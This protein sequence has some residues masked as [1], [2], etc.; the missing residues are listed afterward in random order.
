MCEV[1]YVCVRLCLNLKEIK[2][3][4]T[5]YQRNILGLL[6]ICSAIFDPVQWK[7]EVSPQRQPLCFNYL[8]EQKDCL[9]THCTKS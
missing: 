2:L 4:E 6:Y 9:A 1:R 5:W 3:C 7:A 8:E